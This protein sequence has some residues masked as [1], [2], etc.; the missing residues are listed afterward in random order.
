MGRPPRK[1]KNKNSGRSN[2]PKPGGPMPAAS[3]PAEA[4]SDTMTLELPREEYVSTPRPTSPF[5]PHAIRA[6]FSRNYF[7]Y[8]SNPAGY[9]FITL[10]VLVCA[11][12][13][14][15]Q[16][17]FF[18]NNLANLAPLDNWM[19]Y[20]LLFFIPA[21]TMNA[22]AEERRLGTDE[23][24]LTLPARDVEIVLGKY[25]AALG[26]YTTALV[27]SL[28]LVGLLYKVGTPDLGVIASTYV[29]YW[30]MGALLIAIGLVASV[31]SSNVTVAFILGAVFS[32][33]PVFAGLLGA[34]FSLETRR[35]IED[36]SIPN[37][38][39]D[40]GAGGVPMVGV[41]YFVGLA[42]AMLY[43]NM[44]LLGRRH[45]AGGE[46]SRGL[47]AHAM[48][49]VVALVVALAA[50]DV[51]IARWAN[52]H[53]DLSE[54]GLRRL[55]P[56]S[57]R[58]INDL[59][60]DRPVYIECYYSEDVPRDYVQTKLDLLNKLR[61]FAATSRGKVRLNLV[62]TQLYSD[63]A[64]EAEK[65]FGIKPQRV[66]DTDEAKQAFSEIFLGVAFTSGLE[67]VVVPFFDRGLPVE[68]ELMRSIRVVSKTGRRKLGILQTEVKLL[69]GGMDFRSTGEETE[70]QL[71]TELKKQYDVTSVSPDRPITAEVDVLLVAQPSSLSQQQMNNLTA[72]VKSGK[73][74]LVFVDPLPRFD[75]SLS[76]EEPRRP[77]GN[78]FGGPQPEPKGDI[79]PLLEAL[80]VEWPMGEI[81][82]NQYNPHPQLDVPPEVVFIGRGG[83]GEGAFNPSQPATSGLQEL[84]TFFP[85][86]LRSRSG[87]PDFI[88]LLKSGTEGG[89]VPYSDFRMASLG[90][91]RYRPT[92]EEYTL[93]ARVQ[94]KATPPKPDA[95][96]RDQPMAP[97]QAV[98]SIV[99]AD[100]DIVSD[101]FFNLRKQKV[102][103]LELDNVT[104]VLNCVDVLAGDDSFIDLR[105]R[106]V[107][108][109]TLTKVEEQTK[110][111]ISA[112]QKE[113]KEADDTA[114]K[115]LAAATERLRKEVEA[116]RN[117]TDLDPQTKQIRL[118][119]AQQRETYRLNVERANV[120][121]RRRRRIAD[122]T[123]EREKGIRKTQ[124]GVRIEALLIPPLPVLVL[125]I[126]V[127]AVRLGR[128]NRGAN[129]NRIA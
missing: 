19:P 22:W 31:L 46:R 47:W 104:F 55:S 20:L 102:E 43:L 33:I 3:R 90:R 13:E 23:L 15:W 66:L 82:W 110:V 58:L 18:A 1:P 41:F 113:T 48:V 9:V 27:F 34:P 57:A 35:A 37:Q 74:A 112:A 38:F 117:A 89:T 70:W 103:N 108:H 67:E 54:E 83:A 39:R 52:A 75:P 63:E 25:L 26:I 81:V 12:A 114:E 69:G 96:K 45:W 50:A 78:P 92:G 116:I 84:V 93:A 62:P 71:V 109:R 72:Y 16:P 105:K 115:D 17:V 24:L 40:F 64:R 51:L 11:W 44:I 97:D 28:S 118:V 87:G 36:M 94:G 4:A 106:R 98:N 59:P 76:P 77:A 49:R 125:G 8:F 99:V 10:F 91:R 101:L 127:F 21:I 95:A 88:P 80:G 79:A 121:D 53:A 60:G 85:G 30:L 126:V 2:A 128:E 100:L 14:Y 6:V 107:K 5:R 65:K 119:A 124:T 61:E 73:P 120:E 32:A 29:G 7:A 111:F 129:P 42:V 68:Y 122:I 86:L 56:E 123:T